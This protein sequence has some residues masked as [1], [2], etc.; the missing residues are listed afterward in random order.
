MADNAP[1]RWLPVVGFEDLYEV[2][3]LGRLRSLGR[4]DNRGRRHAPRI[5]RGSPDG[6][7]YIVVVLTAKGVGGAPGQRFPTRMHV[8]VLEAFVGPRPAGMDACHANDV[9]T[10]NRLTNLRWDLRSAN[11]AD[12][13]RNRSRLTTHRIPGT[14]SWSRVNGSCRRGHLLVEPNLSGG[15][16]SR[17][18]RCRA[19]QAGHNAV[20]EAAK[21]GRQLDLD[22]EC[23]RYY[24]L[25]TSTCTTSQ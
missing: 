4:V 1:E 6:E 18:R 5:M 2:S 15:P 23:H 24:S 9:P 25:L 20:R 17:R 8:L 19:C 13:A 16:T 21:Q 3:D 22:T 7:N 14:G 11:H 12:A 10:D